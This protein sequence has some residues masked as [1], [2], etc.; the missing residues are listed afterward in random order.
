MVCK[1]CGINKTE[2]SFYVKDKKTGRR[3]TR[4]KKC[5]KIKS[6][7]R[8]KN[9]SEEINRKRRKPISDWSRHIWSKDEFI[10]IC[11]GLNSKSQLKSQYPG[12]YRK[13]KKQ[14]GTL[15]DSLLPNKNNKWSIEKLDRVIDECVTY[16]DFIKNNNAYKYAHNNGHI[17]YVKSKLVTVMKTDYTDEYIIKTITE[18]GCTKLV[19]I[20]NDPLLKKVYYAGIRRGLKEE[21]HKNIT[22]SLK[23]RNKEEEFKIASMFNTAKELRESKPRTY[24][25]LQQNGSLDEAT[26]HMEVLGSLSKRGLYMYTFPD[27]FIYV[28]LTYDF[29]QRHKEHMGYFEKDKTAVTEYMELTGQTPKREILID[30]TDPQIVSKEEKRLIKKYKSMGISLNRAG[31]GGLGRQRKV[32]KEELIND[33]SKYP[34]KSAWKRG[35]SS[36]YNISINRNRK[37]KG[38][39]DSICKEAGLVNIDRTKWTE[40]RILYYINEHNIKGKSELKFS[41]QSV[42]NSARR[43][44]ILD[45]LGLTTYGKIKK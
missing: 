45:S 44:G 32:S 36:Y 7:K 43:L 5:V 6:R 41:N 11:K 37:E 1:K 8:Y 30:Y 17:D 34:S 23:Y 39:H 4:C 38:Y 2:E 10:D 21:M 9:N 26:K 35:N 13:A 16:A 31:G 15:L 29:I 20:K 33:A 12:L 28:G 3:D 25:W 18:S 14:W 19:E 24:S 40:E 22:L 27:G 42:Y